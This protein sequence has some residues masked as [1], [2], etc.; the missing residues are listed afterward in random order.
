M[1]ILG[2][3]RLR[4][5]GLGN[6]RDKRWERTSK[7]SSL[8]R[9]RGRASRTFRK[10]PEVPGIRD[11]GRVERRLEDGAYGFAKV[12]NREAANAEF[13]TS[14]GTG[15]KR[16]QDPAARV[17]ATVLSVQDSAS[18]VTDGIEVR[19]PQRDF[20]GLAGNG[21]IEFGRFDFRQ[22]PPVGPLNRR[23]RSSRKPAG[24]SSRRRSENLGPCTCPPGA[25]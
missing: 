5:P 15:V 3:F 10:K 11:L 14:P 21:P 17:S 23:N 4:C 20:A 13:F 8:P 24:F 18:D 9:C 12:G 7:R 1:T 16:R 2:R 25:P 6:N 19:D 22:N